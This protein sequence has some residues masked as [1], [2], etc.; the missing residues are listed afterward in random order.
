MADPKLAF[1]LLVVVGLVS[2]FCWVALPPVMRSATVIHGNIAFQI[3][4][5][6]LFAVPLVLVG[7]VGL[8]LFVK[9]RE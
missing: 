2:L 3:S 9:S 1:A 8:V 6:I 5:Y 7:L 4:T